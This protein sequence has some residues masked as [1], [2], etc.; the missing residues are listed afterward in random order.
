[1]LSLYSSC[2]ISPKVVIITLLAGNSVVPDTNLHHI[3]MSSMTVIP[4]D[5]LWSMLLA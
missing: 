4:D 2:Q 1:M 3:E 5:F